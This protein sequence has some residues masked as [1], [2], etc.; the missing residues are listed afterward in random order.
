VDKL[1]FDRS[2]AHLVAGFDCGSAPYAR[3]VSDFIT[4]KTGDVWVAIEQLGMQAWLYR[5]GVEVVGF[6]SLS[7]QDVYLDESNEPLGRLLVIPYFAVQARFH[8]HPP[9]DYRQFYSRQIFRDLVAEARRHPSGLKTLALYVDPAN[10]GAIRLYADP[11]F[12]FR[13][14][15]AFAGYDFI[16]TDLGE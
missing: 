2:L 13:R 10:I 3:E 4:G 8:K 1:P 14:Q 7:L 5:E 9:G 6:G 16:F 15:G 11:E 12:G